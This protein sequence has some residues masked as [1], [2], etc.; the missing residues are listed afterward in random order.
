MRRSWKSR[1][2]DY[3]WYMGISLCVVGLTVL[4]AIYVPDPDLAT[5]LLTGFLG[6]SLIAGYIISSFWKKKLHSTLLTYVAAVVG[7]HSVMWMMAYR[8][9]GRTSAP[10]VS[11]SLIVEIAVLVSVAER[12][13]PDQRR[14]PRPTNS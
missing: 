11:L 2:R 13:L 4:L 6:A 14:S 9:M 10:V 5:Q 1:A 7:A 3:S 8:L 12:I